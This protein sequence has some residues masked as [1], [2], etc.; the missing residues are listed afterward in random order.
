MI[1]PRKFLNFNCLILLHTRLGKL[2]QGKLA[3]PYFKNCFG[4]SQ[5]YP[6]HAG[7]RVCR[8]TDREARYGDSNSGSMGQDFTMD[9]HQVLQACV[10]RSACLSSSNHSASLSLP[11]P[12]P[13][14]VHRSGSCCR[15]FMQ[16][17]GIQVC[18]LL[19]MVAGGPV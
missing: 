5:I 15:P 8:E 7:K 16:W 10:F 13:I 19:S 17:T 12:H 14:V 1:F 3:N 11:S 2:C 4:G 6:P 18:C 9:S